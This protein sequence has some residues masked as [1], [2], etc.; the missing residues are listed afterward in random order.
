MYLAHTDQYKIF[1]TFFVE[2]SKRS[3]NTFI[4]RHEADA[5]Y[6]EKFTRKTEVILSK[7]VFE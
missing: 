3:T 6:N 5:A 1:L 7:L 4:A 2:T